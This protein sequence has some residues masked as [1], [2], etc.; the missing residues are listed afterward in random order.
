MFVVLFHWA[1][2]AQT[3]SP[4]DTGTTNEAPQVIPPVEVAPVVTNQFPATTNLFPTIK[5]KTATKTN[6]AYVLSSVAGNFGGNYSVSGRTLSFPI[7]QATPHSAT[8]WRRNLDFGMNMTQGNSDTLRY[9]LGCEAVK[10]EDVNTFRLRARGSYGESDGIKDTENAGATFRYDRQLTKKVYAFGTLD[11]LTDPIAELDY[12]YT[13]ILSPG[14]H[15]VRTKTT[16]LNVEIG[17]GYVEEKKD[18]DEEGYTAGRVALT[19]EKLIND[20]FLVWATSEY[21]PKLADIS[22]F[23]INSEIGLASYIT[24]DL[25]LT[26]F[27][28]N[29]YDSTPV[30]GVTGSDTIF[31]TALSLNF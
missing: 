14:Y 25:S 24:R 26:M 27:Y 3:Q 5:P 1:S 13:G 31:T 28:Q 21:I 17:A 30:E 22:V 7:P 20:H 6:G 2:G 16:I 4:T 8:S 10:T 9:S 15:L 18:N 12:R 29:R 19:A 11:W 23:F